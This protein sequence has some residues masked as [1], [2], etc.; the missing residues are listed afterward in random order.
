MFRM[1]CPSC[2][3][4]LKSAAPIAPG[5]KV[6]CPGCKT[7]F[8][9]PAA[10]TK[11]TPQPREDEDDD[12]PRKP[13]GIK[14]P[15]APPPGPRAG[16]G[17]RKKKPTPPP[18]PSAFTAFEDDEEEDTLPPRKKAP[19]SPARGKSKVKPPDEDEDDDFDDEEDEEESPRSR[20]TAR[21]KS[22]LP[23]IL[24]LAG[25]GVALVGLFL[26]GAFVWPGFLASSDHGP[27]RPK[28]G[29]PGPGPGPVA[30]VVEPLSYIPADAFGVVGADLQAL[31]GNPLTAPLVQEGLKKVAAEGGPEKVFAAIETLHFGLWGDPDKGDGVMIFRSASPLDT[32]LVKQAF[33]LQEVP[34][35]EFFKVDEPDG[36]LAQPDPKI[37]VLAPQ[38]DPIA[39]EKVLAGGGPDLVMAVELRELVQQNKDALLYFAMTN[40]PASK[41]Q[42]RKARA[43]A[44]PKSPFPDRF[45]TI[46]ENARAGTVTLRPD[47]D[48]LKIQIGITCA[49]ETDAPELSKMVQGTWDTQVKPLLALAPFLLAKNKGG[50]SLNQTLQDITKSFKVE[51]IGSQA[52]A[53]IRFS[54]GAMAELS[55]SLPGLAAGLK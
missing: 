18:A 3:K 34:G 12:G 55:K 54:P 32:D 42:I 20:R 49:Q 41:D 6:R 23:L 14:K 52:V 45:W 37:L 29:V 15:S 51:T 50:P 19:P 40:E 1:S 28:G 38:K 33:K 27:I 35:K 43:M 21:K 11:P 39:A 48:G 22:S 36:F 4:E 24:I 10:K 26:V 2:G 53:S 5:K 47:G 31:R 16:A 9:P 17:I 30:K 8:A 44:G 25:T 46:L 7:V 13:S